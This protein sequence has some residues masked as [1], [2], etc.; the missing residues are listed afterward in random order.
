MKDYERTV[1]LMINKIHLQSYYEY[2]GRFVTG[3]DTNSQ[4]AANT[5]SVFMIQSHLSPKKN[6][7][8]I[9]P[10]SQIDAK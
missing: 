1:T 4:N 8:H 5:A 7:V 10:V 6:V 9:I 3:A 2:K